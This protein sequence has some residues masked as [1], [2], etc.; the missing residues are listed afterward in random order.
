MD[1]AP[2]LLFLRI[3]LEHLVEGVG[4]GLVRQFGILTD[5]EL[6]LG[7]FQDIISAG[8][9]HDL[10]EPLHHDDGIVERDLLFLV[11]V[12]VPGEIDIHM[13]EIEPGERTGLAESHPD[14]V[15]AQVEVFTGEIG[16]L[17][18]LFADG[19]GIKLPD[20]VDVA[21]EVA[22]VGNSLIAGTEEEGRAKGKE[23]DADELF[24]EFVFYGV[25]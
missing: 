7:Q 14:F 17:Y 6:V 1:Q 4:G 11:I 16:G 20:A 13:V 25:T 24:H 10:P 12:G 22:G 2:L 18:G 21:G 9:A 15:Q 3:R 19:L 5:Y 23:G 8:N